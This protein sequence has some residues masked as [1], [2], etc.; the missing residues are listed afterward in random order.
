MAAMVSLIPASY[1]PSAIPASFTVKT[2]SQTYSTCMMRTASVRTLPSHPVQ[3]DPNSTLK[4]L[5]SWQHF[6]L[7][8]NSFAR[9]FFI[10]A[11][12]WCAVLVFG[13]ARH[14]CGLGYKT[15]ERI[16]PFVVASLAALTVLLIR[17]YRFGVPIAIVIV[18][19]YV[20][21]IFPAYS[22]WIHGPNAPH[23]PNAAMPTS[24][25]DDLKMTDGGRSEPSAKPD[26]AGH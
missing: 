5:S 26:N 24:F 19:I 17:R 1:S 10:T 13:S 18:L 7:R 21:A 4:P 11:F 20:F 16:A 8:F 6:A 23:F 25:L 22:S 14:M 12:T 9:R 2:N 15:A 3:E